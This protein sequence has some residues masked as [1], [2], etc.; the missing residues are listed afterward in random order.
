MKT[1]RLLQCAVIAGA[2]FLLCAGLLFGCRKN[3]GTSGSVETDDTDLY[4]IDMQPAGE[5]PAAVKYPSVY[6]QFSKPVVAVSVLGEPSDTSE[7]MSITPPLKGVYRWYGTSLLCFESSD[8][9]IAQREYTVT[10]PESVKSVDGTRVTGQLEY[11]FHTEELSMLNIIPGYE[12]VQA[13][14]FVDTNNM[15]PEEA[16][17]IG[18]MFSY[19]V[20]PET[21][22]QSIAVTAL[23]PETDD[24]SSGGSVLLP[25]SA[26]LPDKEQPELLL[27]ALKE[28]PPENAEIVVTLEE[29]ARSEPEALPVSK[30][31]SFSFHTLQDFHLV[32]VSPGRTSSRYSNPVEFYFSHRLDENADLSKIKVRTEPEMPVSADNLAVSGRTLIVHGLPVDFEQTYTISLQGELADAYNRV[33]TISAGPET[34]RVPK[35]DSYAA[36]KDSGF[37]ILENQFEPKL[38]FEHQNALVGSFYRVNA[39]TGAKADMEPDRVR[40]EKDSFPENTRILQPVELRPYLTETN[41]GKLSGAVEFHAEIVCD[42]DYP[43]SDK[44]TYTY[45]NEQIIQVTDLGMTVRY[46]AGRAAVLVSSLSTGKPVE[47][48]VVSAYITKYSLKDEDVITLNNPV[49]QST[50][51][52]GGLAVI[53]LPVVSDS[54]TDNVYFRAEKD[55]DTV[56]FNP[57]AYGN[58]IWGSYIRAADVDLGYPLR[59][60]KVAFMFTDRGLYKPGETL[61]VRGIDRNLCKGEYSPYSGSGKLVIREAKWNGETILTQ[62]EDVSETGGF[63]STFQ[64]PADMK[65]G[66]YY[67]T[68]S[69]SDSEVTRIPFTVSYFERLRFES[70]VSMPDLTY[71]S[72]DMVS[73]GI[74][75]SYLGGGSL[76]GV[77]WSG[78]WYREPVSFRPE[79]SAYDNFIFGPQ[80]GYDGRTALT[81]GSGALDGNGSASAS[82]LS[83]GEKTAG[84]PY[85]YRFESTVTDAG[86]Q[87]VSAFGSA[88]VHPAQYY[89]GVSKPKGVNGF[90]KKG[91]QIDFDFVLVT[92]DSTAP[93]SDCFP[94]N[95]AGQAITAELLREDWKKVQQVGLNGNLITRYVREMVSEEKKTVPLSETGSFSMTPPK[96][97]AYIVRL[98]AEDSKS[99]QIITERSFYVSGSDW[100]YYYGDS[101]DE[102][103]LIADKTLYNVGDTAQIMLQSPLPA[104][105]YL[106][107]VERE[108][109]FSEKVFHL[110][111]PTTVLEVPIDEKYLPVVYVAVS[112]YSVRTKEPDH[113]FSSRD[114]DK[115]KGYFG[116]VAL[117]VDTS[118]KEFDITVIQDKVSYRPGEKATFTLTATKDGKPLPG[119]ELTLMAVDRGVI[120]LINYHVPDPVEFFYD[121]YRFPSRVAGDDSRSLLIDPVTY[122]VRNLYGGDEGGDKLNERKNFDPT[123]VFEP[124][125][126]T[127]SDGT[128]TCSFELPDNLTEYRVTVIGMK[129]DLFARTEDKLT[130]NNPLSARDVL[131]R[132]LREG[133]VSDIGVVISNLDG[134]DHTATITMEITSGSETAAADAEEAGTAVKAGKASV[135]G[136]AVKTVT[137][138]AGRTVPALFDM[139]AEN[140]GMVTVSFTVKSDVLNERIIKPLEIER[141]LIYETVTTVGEVSSGSVEEKGRASAKEHII[142]PSGI[143]AE[144]DASVYVSLDPTRL[145][146]LT[147]AVSY[148][149]RYPYGCLEQ[150]CSAMIPLLYFSD[151]IDVFGLESEVSNPR[152][153]IETEIKDWGTTQKS[154]GGFPYWKNSS[155]ASLAAS[156]RFAELIA[157]SLEQNIL[158]DRNIDIDALIGYILDAR[159]DEYLSKNTY[160]QA[161]SLYILQKL[162]YRVTS[163]AIQKVYNMEGSGFSEKALCGLMYLSAG[164]KTC[165]QTVAEEIRAHCRP[166]TRGID[167]T[168]PEFNSSP[169]MYFND[170]SERNALLLQF[171]TALDYSDSINGRLLHNLLELQ[172]A[173]NGYWKNTASTARVLEAVAYYIEANN[174]ENLDFTGIAEL[175]GK[176]IMKE[177]F[178][179]AAAKPEAVILPVN[180]LIVSGIP[181]GKEVPFEFSKNGRGSMFYTL[182]MKY[183]LPYEQQYARDEGLSVFVDITDVATGKTVTGNQLESGKIY[184][185]RAT[186]STTKDRT[187]VA[188]R[189]PIPSGAEVLNAAFA[190]TAQFAGTA[191]AEQEADDGRSV[192]E[193]YNFGLSSQEIY[194]NEVRYFW[195]AF[196]KGR[197]QVEFMFRTV[198]IG[199]FNVPSATAE[200]MYE[201][202]IFGRSKGGVFVIAE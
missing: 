117:H 46:G 173:G 120:D 54:D 112:S 128:V 131:P 37:K 174:L 113:D 53:T 162:G 51:N 156:L 82:Q 44:K 30:D 65:P 187:F 150:R 157:G 147:E 5:L 108:T 144:N 6:V 28:A 119:A 16:R 85:L 184:R 153:V 143:T 14:G 24:G 129:D 95:K 198:R 32:S 137:V 189:V 22:S 31:K 59:T 81:T 89:I 36:F 111:E 55:G 135:S 42:Y 86:G 167:I 186:V 92:P 41:N 34:V 121:E 78:S 98:T 88:V 8:P 4:I 10:I 71:I 123:A 68:Y 132:R 199:E 90:P 80:R 84:S 67:I 165:A 96:A 21:I 122:E 185:V 83:G 191:L 102:I 74:S 139:K 151:Y 200:C 105:T 109:I 159:Q 47:G 25:F 13:G 19:P 202:E 107:T 193:R 161:Y 1:K 69:R 104:G 115:P 100:S 180:D 197:Q 79:G 20:Q 146:T 141:P 93:G 136:T 23:L 66:S 70:S 166:T 158:V 38:V 177:S 152:Q 64:L 170:E 45:T 145:G 73:A 118:P 9:V 126:V 178:K 171:F 188:L 56:I 60:T 148:V 134:K 110:D 194:D 29:G 114:M 15:L 196:R 182:S 142:L 63:T 48:A 164:D 124:V 138:P 61:R 57:S 7:Y 154:D 40:F 172:R 179:G 49:A 2:G 94:A 130:V 35:A 133:D 11:H 52:S 176:E 163:S 12:T 33:N 140:N 192:Y 127:G 72:G 58:R 87:A 103:P 3:N 91:Q 101:S 195:D 155:D 175:D 39:L 116:S 99:R 168:D 149:F 50:T 77:S 75:A 43:W 125:L 18:V 76:A 190:T 27:L 26:S 181:A 97:G 160:F 201:P 106:M 169:W 17:S 62:W 183:P